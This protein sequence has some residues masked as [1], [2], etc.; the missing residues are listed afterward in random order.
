[1]QKFDRGDAD[2]FTYIVKDGVKEFATVVRRRSMTLVWP[3]TRQALEWVF[4]GVFVLA[5]CL[6]PAPHGPPR[7]GAARSTVTCSAGRGSYDERPEMYSQTGK[8]FAV[9]RL[10]VIHDG[11]DMP[12]H[13]RRARTDGSQSFRATTYTTRTSTESQ[14]PPLSMRWATGSAARCG[15]QPEGHCD[16]ARPQPEMKRGRVV[17]HARGREMTQTIGGKKEP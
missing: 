10:I 17:R 14:T 6:L 5:A 3:T 8:T 12:A 7:E 9:H 16:G 13:P 2:E 15:R 1:M 11:M 4:I